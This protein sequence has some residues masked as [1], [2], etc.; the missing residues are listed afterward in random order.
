MIG[1][2]VGNRFT[3]DRI[4]THF[5]RE[6]TGINSA[7]LSTVALG[8][9]I[10]ED[11]WYRLML[12]LAFTGSDFTIT[13]QVF[14]HT[15]ATDPN[16]GLGL[17]I[18]ATLSYTD[19]APWTVG[20]S[21]PYEIGLVARG[22]SAVVDTSITNFDFSGGVLDIEPVPEPASLSLFGTGCLALA[23]GLFRRRRRGSATQS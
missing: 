18:G 7:N 22:V 10:A 13:G 9:G 19:I 2:L 17:Q 15:T 6:R 12:G 1:T 4:G 8:S 20:L 23:A 3:L 14:P 21:D 5:Y 11:T 16:S